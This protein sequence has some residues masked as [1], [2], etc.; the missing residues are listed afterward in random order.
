ML[1]AK[2]P[3]IMDTILGFTGSEDVPVLRFVCSLWNDLLKSRRAAIPIREE[4][5]SGRAALGRL[6]VLKWA[7]AKGCPWEERTCSSA[8][9]GGH[10]PLLQWARDNGCP[11]DQF[12]CAKA[13]ANGNLATFQWAVSKSCPC[14][15]LAT[16]SAAS[17]GCLELLK[18]A[19]DIVGCPWYIDICASAA[20]FGGHLL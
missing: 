3:E 18:W 15:L 2:P 7:R 1:K 9:R 8:A 14:D 4:F 11:W 20:V 19:V 6:S 10:L 5:C 13:A 16:A 12:T 17:G